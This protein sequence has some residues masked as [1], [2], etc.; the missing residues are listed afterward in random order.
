MIIGNEVKT[1][2]YIYK[3]DTKK[4][5]YADGTPLYYPEDKSPYQLI[6]LW[7]DED[8]R[9]Q[10]GKA[11]YQHQED[12][13]SFIR[14]DMLSDTINNAVG[15]GYLPI[16]LKHLKSKLTFIFIPSG[17]GADGSTVTNLT[18]N[19]YKP[20]Y[21]VTMNPVVITYQ[22]IYDFSMEAETTNISNNK[23]ALRLTTTKD[24]AIEYHFRFDASS[25]KA[26][27][28]REIKVVIQSPYEIK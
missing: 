8:T 14:C 15:V 16:Y 27:E 2:K 5:E 4:L 19:G 1:A 7:P 10:L 12:K 22:L 11:D 6:I 24:A 3:A 23:G 21:V 28:S 18:V 13:N 17:W 9:M 25:L 26:G 20:F